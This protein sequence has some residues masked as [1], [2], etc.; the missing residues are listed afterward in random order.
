MEQSLHP[1]GNPGGNPDSTHH[2]AQDNSASASFLTALVASALEA[3]RAGHS[4][5]AARLYQDALDIDPTN[6]D[7]LHYLGVLQHQQGNHAAALNLLD[8]ALELAPN[9]A[10]C[11]S[12][13]GI[14]AAASGQSRDAIRCYL[15]ALQLE[16]DF[17]DA[18]NN[19]G[20]ALQAQDQLQAAVH[21][22]QQALVLA[23]S[24]VDAHL[25]LG[26]ALARLE[27]YDEA[28]ASYEHALALDPHSAE[29][30][31]NAGNALTSK[32]DS[33]AAIA[34]FK[35]AIEL[36]PDFA[37]AH[38]NLGSATGKLGNYAAAERHYRL[39]V[40]I[41]PNPANLVCLGG[42][43]GAQGRL[44]EEEVFY[45]R[46]LQ[47]DPNYVDAHQNLAWM[48][49]KRG[50][51]A[52]GWAEFAKRW[53]PQDYAAIAVEGVTEWH[54]E[55]LEG[56]SILL[57]G[58]Q[59]LG[60]QLQFL[61]YA[62]VL[63]QRDATVDVLV[64]EPLVPLAQRVPGVRRAWSGKAHDRYDFWVPL[65]SVPSCVGTDLSTIPAE[66]PYVFADPA[67]IETWRKRVNDAAGARRNIGL[68][69]AGSPTYG[70]DRYR[71]MQFADLA[72]LGEV[73]DIAWFSLQK[74]PA[75]AQLTDAPANFQ[76]SDFTTDLTDFDE[77]AALVMNL[78]LV[79][80]VDT[81]VAHLA[82]ALGKPVWVLL[83]ANSDW[84]WL[85]NRSDSPWYPSARLFRQEVLGDWE[86]VMASVVQA[87]RSESA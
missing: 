85:E 17:A 51:Y 72:A 35:R 22:Y 46:A 16:P 58:D 71:S 56:R 78:D 68:V 31:F 49:L 23:P 42:S 34:R 67:K 39:A 4:S 21:Q 26:T 62:R 27:R 59:G 53:R 48:L 3:H 36:R 84:R 40:E 79:I 1:G 55:P 37:K 29:A 6:I 20:V 15:Q 69:W 64:R 12:N 44:D 43:L 18:R 83:P 87:L 75:Q 52:Q 73:D 38:I 47:I 5:H 65:M 66:V 7:A 76:P 19:L 60:D 41:N 45:R 74:G 33:L 10:A 13:R 77:T 50:D 9:N 57:V 81:G 70:N 30:H 8:K 24:L 32:G 61:R 54:G 11:W 2:H 25:N 63:E 14:V 80:T 82:G 28:L 86:P